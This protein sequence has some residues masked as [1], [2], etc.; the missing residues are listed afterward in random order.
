MLNKHTVGLTALL[1]FSPLYAGQNATFQQLDS[2]AN[3]YISPDEA[4]TV[5]GLNARWNDLDADKNNLLDS[6]EFSAFEIG[7]DP[8]KGMMD[9][10]MGSGGMGGGSTTEPVQDQAPITP[11]GVE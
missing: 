6:S 3:G 10:S 7:S 11:Q 5:D 8:S 1:V 4:Q 2:D 9:D